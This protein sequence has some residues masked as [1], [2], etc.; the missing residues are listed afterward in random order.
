[1]LPNGA[2]PFFRVTF[3]QVK[4]PLRF[5]GMFAEVNAL[6]PDHLRAKSYGRKRSA[7]E[8]AVDKVNDGDGTQ[9]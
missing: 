8:A 5:T 9:G 4:T 6:T 1:M 3:E 7:R 2:A